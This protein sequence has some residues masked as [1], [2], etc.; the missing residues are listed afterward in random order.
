[1][2]ATV[3]DDLEARARELL[4]NPS[5][6][7]R[8]ALPVDYEGETVAALVRTER[9]RARGAA[10]AH[11]G[12]VPVGCRVVARHLGDIDADWPRLG[13]FL[14]WYERAIVRVVGRAIVAAGGGLAIIEPAGSPVAAG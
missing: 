6:R 2:K 9:G 1:M 7:A 4:R 11:L 3:I 8:W 10:L 12:E 14:V 13:W 5:V